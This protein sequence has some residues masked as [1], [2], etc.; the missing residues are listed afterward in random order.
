[1]K[2]IFT[3]KGYISALSLLA[4]WSLSLVVDLPGLAISPVVSV[5]DKVFKDATHLECQ[6]LEILPN[7]CI[8]PFILLSGKLSESRNKVTLV[9]TGL[10]IFLLSGVAYF[11]CD[12]IVSLIIVSCTLGMGCG[13]IIPLAAG[14]LAE[15]FVGKYRLQ[16]MGIKSGIANFTLV[17]ATFAVGLIEGKNWHLPFVVYLIAV[18]PLVMSI[19]LTGRFLGN[20]TSAGSTATQAPQVAKPAQSHSV[21]VR[22]WGI[23]VFYT[24][25]T[26]TG[27]TLSFFIP[28]LMQKHAMGDAATGYVSAAFYLALTVPG[29]WLGSVVR[30]LRGATIPVCVAA[31]ICGLIIIPVVPALWAYFAGAVLVGFGYGALQPIFYDKAAVLAPSSRNSTRMLS[32]IMA[33]NYIGVAVCPLLF[34]G[35]SS[36]FAFVISAVIMT[37][38]LVMSLFFRRWYIFSV[39]D[40]IKAYQQTPRKN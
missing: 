37:G 10:A 5:I 13:L 11:F 17:F 25:V 7:F 14:L 9:V 27:I 40:Q 38:V 30:F 36:A 15:T 21:T 12:N 33:A 26:V 35:L 32:Y 18:I 22:I 3:G 16:Q 39:A 31:M 6:L 34:A 19:F 4:I 8:F 24:L 2:K 28:F 29:F 23:I 1:M 20:D